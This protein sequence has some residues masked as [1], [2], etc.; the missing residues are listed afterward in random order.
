LSEPLNLNDN[1][2]YW[3]SINNRFGNLENIPIRVI[4]KWTVE[5]LEKP[6]SEIYTGWNRDKTSYVIHADDNLSSLAMLVTNVEPQARDN[7]YSVSI[8]CSN[9]ECRYHK[10]NKEA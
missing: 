3:M 6:V 1:Y 10:D 7:N 8:T 5:M 9:Y 2:S 4:D